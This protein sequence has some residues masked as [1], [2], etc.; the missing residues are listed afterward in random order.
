MLQNGRR[1]G[2]QFVETQQLYLHVAG[3]PAAV[4][5][6]DLAL[7]E[8]PVVHQALSLLAHLGR[9]RQREAVEPEQ[10]GEVR[11]LRQ[12]LKTEA[13]VPAVV[14]L[15][16]AGKVR[17]HVRVQFRQLQFIEGEGAEVGQRERLF[18]LDPVEPLA[19]DPGPVRKA[20]AVFHLQIAPRI[21]D[22]GQAL[23]AVEGGEIGT[24]LYREHPDG[25][26][27]LHAGQ[28]PVSAFD[29]IELAGHVGQRGEVHVAAVIDHQLPDGLADEIGSRRGVIA[30]GVHVQIAVG[31][32]SGET[33][34]VRTLID[35]EAQ[36]DVLLDGE[37]LQKV[38]IVD[39]HPIE[40]DVLEPGEGAQNAHVVEIVVPVAAQMD[41]FQLDAPRQRGD[42]PQPIAV[43]DIQVPQVAH[44]LDP[45][46]GG[47]PRV[48]VQ[49]QLLQIPSFQEGQVGQIGV[50]Q[51][52]LLQA[53][54]RGEPAKVAHL[55]AQI[56]LFQ[57]GEVQ[58][59][60]LDLLVP[61]AQDQ[62]VQLAAVA[63]GR[64]VLQCVPVILEAGD[65]GPLQTL[66]I[67]DLAVDDGDGL[68]MLQGGKV[69]Q[70]SLHVDEGHMHQIRQIREVAHVAQLRHGDLLA[71][72]RAEEGAHIA[73]IVGH[74]AVGLPLR[75]AA[76]LAVAHAV[77]GLIVF[78]DIAHIHHLG[79]LGEV[80]VDALHGGR[81]GGGGRR[82]RRG[83]RRGFGRGRRGG[84]RGG[85]DKEIPKVRLARPVPGD[86]PAH[87][88]QGCHAQ[89]GQDQ[90]QPV[91][92]LPAGRL[93]DE[94]CQLRRPVLS[95]VQGV[96]GHEQV[97]QVLRGRAPVQV[98]RDHQL[99]AA[100]QP[101]E[102]VRLRP[103]GADG[104]GQEQHQGVVF[105]SLRL[106]VAHRKASFLQ[107]VQDGPYAA[108]VIGGVQGVDSSFHGSLPFI[109]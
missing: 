35:A 7:L 29:Q 99:P 14:D 86:E 73:G 12:V 2:V 67:R 60:K 32:D 104:F 49:E 108:F 22:A 6:D 106:A 19:F 50:L 52:D 51:V 109:I 20:R 66:D 10:G 48:V 15:L 5:V 92:L 74:L 70:L 46:E 8:L 1:Q 82:R 56:Q 26:Q 18:D 17:Q 21:A 45:R 68:E 84:G 38:Q 88:Q 43:F 75:V 23:Q 98:H 96:P 91:L 33:R 28:I 9:H 77:G 58:I 64:K 63:E 37:V 54:G 107:I 89:Q 100:V 80:H 4:G 57:L 44:A 90:G 71:G 39:G 42:V 53:V 79:H 36:V 47:E 16:Q 55:A 59:A 81:R 93:G 65:G 30:M 72:L 25:A 13:V 95:A 102:G 101:E 76:E 24:V 103:L 11:D 69:R 31:V 34:V 83:L 97:L 78:E 62:V 41:A 105:A 40:V 94:L 27:R 87:H 61:G 85:L 3:V